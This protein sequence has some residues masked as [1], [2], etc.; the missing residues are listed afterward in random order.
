MK[1]KNVITRI[2]ISRPK[3]RNV[4]KST[5]KNP[6]KNPK[7]DTKKPAKPK[8]RYVYKGGQRKISQKDKNK[9]DDLGY[10]PYSWDDVDIFLNSDKIIAVGMLKGVKRYLYKKEFCKQQS[11]K[12]C[13]RMIKF[14]KELNNIKSNIMSLMNKEDS[15]KKVI[16][17]GLW[18]MLMSSIR[19][20]NTKYLKENG[21]YGLTTLHKKHVTVK[22]TYIELDFVGK[23]SVQ[24]YVK[25]KL[26]N[27]KFYN[28][29]QKL[30]KKASPYLLSYKGSR[31]NAQEINDYIKDYYGEEFTA[32][33]FRTWGANIIFLK[34][35]AELRAKDLKE[36]KPKELNKVVKE[37]IEHTADKLNNTPSV[38]KSNYLCPHILEKFKCEPQSLVKKIQKS[39][40]IDKL[41][42]QLL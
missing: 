3:V 22:P 11:D 28:W 19:V 16:A 20:G 2:T 13:D 30:Y 8:F 39:N 4:K 34:R 15:R 31:V 37:L 42:I 33:D 12:K 35:V 17:T 29:F 23:K 41:L 32:K 36:L 14:G 1:Q 24:N 27:K 21:T 10:I 6:K 26:P 38:L 9:I 5:K 40:D 25:I 18:I 7:N